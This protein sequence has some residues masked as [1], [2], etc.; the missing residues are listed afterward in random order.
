MVR[1]NLNQSEAM[2]WFQTQLP[3]YTLEAY[4][5][6]NERYVDVGAFMSDFWGSYVYYTGGIIH[7]LTFDSDRSIV[8]ALNVM[9]AHHFNGQL[10]KAYCSGGS[11]MSS[12]SVPR[13]LFHGEEVLPGPVFRVLD[14]VLLLHP[15]LRVL[16]VLLHDLPVGVGGVS[17]KQTG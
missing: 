10:P 9:Q 16:P 13:I 15:V 2:E 8:T 4:D 1:V 5:K 11:F 6:N 7:A 14:L 17:H 3:Q 12:R